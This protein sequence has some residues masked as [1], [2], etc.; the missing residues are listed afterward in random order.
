MFERRVTLFKLLGFEVRIDPSWL[1]LA[2][3]IT[4]T[5]AQGV[6]PGRYPGLTQAAYWIMG[7]AGAV[8]LFASIVFHELSHSLVARAYGIPMKGITLFIFGGVA[9]MDDEPP[10]PRAELAMAAAG[11]A[12]SILLGLLFYLVHLLAARGGLA[13]PAVGVFYY[14]AMINGILAVF[15]LIPGFPLDGGRIL[16]ALLWG[17]K[18]SIRRATRI[19]SQIGSGFGTL[20]FFLGALDVI[21]GN[22]VG[23]LWLFLI[24]MFLRNASQMS[25]RQLLARTAFQGE[26][27]RRFMRTDPVTVP[28]GASVAALVEDYIYRH[29]YKM[30]PVVRDGRLV[31][32]VSTREVK[33]VPR[34][35]WEGRTVAD[36]MTARSCE[37]SVS[38]EEDAVAAIAMMNR[39]GSSR[40]LVV[41]GDRL[42]GIVSLKDMLK[43]LSLK[44]DLEGENDR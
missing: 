17:W 41:D 33:A 16:R 8:G 42:A 13:A 31:G 9:E 7:A 23:G 14:L 30:F 11:P 29:H 39:T 10:S 43:F 12:S 21:T 34:Q 2:L 18:G 35:E 25:Y 15:N 32:C 5:L 19:A 20:L 38:P 27:V 40:L 4:W 28:A 44:I 22:L 24:G 37:N 1:I 3:L 6:F 26:P 36:I